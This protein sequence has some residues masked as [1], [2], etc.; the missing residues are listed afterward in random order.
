[1][2]LQFIDNVDVVN[3]QLIVLDWVVAGLN[4]S[5]VPHYYYPG[6]LS[7]TAPCS[8]PLLP[9]AGS[10]ASSL[11]LRSGSPTHT[12]QGQLYCFSR[13]GVKTLS[14][15]CR[16]GYT[17]GAWGQLSWVQLVRIR[18]S[19]STVETLGCQVSHL[20]QVVMGVEGKAS[21]MHIY[22]HM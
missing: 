16:R 11:T 1:M 19:S 4:K 15:D 6:K 10:K 21:F 12:T 20:L 17:R 8:L 7:S 22:C 14:I 5:P 18:A 3:G 13:W 9:A 2:F